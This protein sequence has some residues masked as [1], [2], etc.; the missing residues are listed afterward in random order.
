MG[1]PDLRR[2]AVLSALLATALAPAAFAAARV[3]VVGC[4]LER[5]HADVI[6]KALAERG[7]VEGKTFRFEP[8]EHRGSDSRELATAVRELVAA[9]PDAVLAFWPYEIAALLAA[10][11]AIPIVCGPI[12]DPVAAGFAQSLRRPGGN[13]TGLSTGSHE[14]W[15]F[16]IGALRTLRPRLRR[17][18]VV[19]SPGMPVTVQ[20]RSH[21]EA[22]LAAGLDWAHAPVSSVADAER[23]LATVVGEAVH[24]APIETSSL[25]QS[26]LE[27]AHRRQALTFGGWRGCLMGY[28]RYFSDEEQRLA[29]VL[30]K[31][32]RGAAPA[33]IPFELPDR[34]HF[35]LNRAV[36]RRLGVELPAE[37]L[38]RATQVTDS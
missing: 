1:L 29:A 27:F 32:L 8:R 19:H 31:V 7:H 6:G 11:R 16:V 18:L 24:M 38:L 25:A 30:D 34:T 26:V 9:K 10:T 15:E 36:A 20:M 22:A 12:P 5:K 33:D 21:R 37:M 2:R 23:A 13:V 14:I 3:R 4:F 35:A 28:S 17:I